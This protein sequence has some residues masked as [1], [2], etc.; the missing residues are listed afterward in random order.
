MPKTGI[1]RARAGERRGSGADHHG[2]EVPGSQARL[3]EDLLDHRG[4]EL[5]VAALLDH[6]ARS[7]LRPQVVEE[8]D[9]HRR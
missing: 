8:R 9:G 2:L 7:E 4:E 3:G 5:G 6:P 1:S